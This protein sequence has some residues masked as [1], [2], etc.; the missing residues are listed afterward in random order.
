MPTSTAWQT[1]RVRSQLPIPISS[2]IYVSLHP[3]SFALAP[4]HG[5]A[6]VTLS[7]LSVRSLQTDTAIQ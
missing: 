5:T 3:V 1:H 2:L 7:D 4:P 6:S